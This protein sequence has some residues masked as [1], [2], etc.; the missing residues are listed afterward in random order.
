MRSSVGVGV[1][2]AGT[3]SAIGRSDWGIWRTAC[4][5]AAITVHR[6][7]LHGQ[8]AVFVLTEH[9]AGGREYGV[10][11]ALRF[12]ERDPQRLREVGPRDGGDNQVIS[13][14]P[15]R[16]CMRS[17]C[18]GPMH[19]VEMGR[20]PPSGFRIIDLLARGSKALA[21]AS[22][23]APRTRRLTGLESVGNIDQ[24]I[25][26]SRCKLLVAVYAE[27]AGY[28]CLAGTISAVRQLLG[29]KTIMILHETVRPYVAAPAAYSGEPLHW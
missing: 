3:Q 6:A 2:T 17:P 9:L 7:V 20:P 11:T 26:Q 16:T 13:P 15:T 29:P 23:G 5:R 4:R 22:D 14:A 24:E 19:H 18:C 12:V 21:T 10:V 25:R 1:C 8:Q 27:F 28:W